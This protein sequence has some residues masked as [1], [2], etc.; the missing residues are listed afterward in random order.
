MPVRERL[1]TIC[2]V[3]HVLLCDASLAR[4]EKVDDIG[5]VAQLER[6]VLGEDAR[7]TVV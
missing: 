7:R 3:S 1:L 2:A 5:D 6:C 4:S